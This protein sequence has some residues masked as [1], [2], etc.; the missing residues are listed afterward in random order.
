MTATPTPLSVLYVEPD[1]AYRERVERY[2]DGPESGMSVVAVPTLDAARSR[3]RDAGAEF[4]CVVAEYALPDADG[5]ELIE[6]VREENPALPVVV[7]T[8]R[9]AEGL[10]EEAFDRGATD[11]L[12]KQSGTEQYAVLRRRIEAAVATGRSADGGAASAETRGDADSTFAEV[13][14]VGYITFDAGGD[15]VHANPRA[16]SLLG[17]EASELR[18]LTYDAA[19]FDIVDSEGEPIPEEQLPFARALRSKSPVTDAE[20]GV[21]RPGGERVWL[22]VNATPLYEEG[23]G[24]EGDS[25]GDGDGADDGDGER[26]ET[27]RGVIATFQDVTNRV[28]V[29][30]TLNEVLDRTTDSFAA[31]DTEWRYTYVN[32]A[33]ARL[34]GRPAEDHIGQVIWDL[35]PDSRAFW[36]VSHEAMETQEPTSFEAY[37][38]EP[39]DRWT[40][41][42]LYPSESGLSI[43]LRDISNRKARERELE[44]YEAIVQTVTDGICVLDDEWRFTT[45]NDAFV[46]MTG[47]SREELVGSRADAVADVADPES[48]ARLHAELIEERR[49]VAAMESEVETKSGERLP[50]EAWLAPITFGDETHGVVGVVRDVT[51]RKRSAEAFTELYEAAHDL[52]SATTEEEIARIAVEASRELLSLPDAVLFRYDPD[53]RAFVHLAHSPEIASRYPPVPT[54]PADEASLIRRAF[55][56]DEVLAF[57]DV[58]DSETL[59]HTEIPMRRG[60]FIPLGEYG[61]LLAGETATGAFDDQTETLA[62]LLGTTIRAA[63]DRLADEQALRERQWE[64]RQQTARLERLNQINELIRGIDERL[65]DARTREAVERAVCEQLVANDRYA[66]A[67]VGEYDRETETVRPRTWEGMDR[68]YLEQLAA[69]DAEER[70]TEPADRAARERAVVV[71]PNVVDG[72]REN[73]WRREALSR[74]FQS[75]ISVPLHYDE[76]P[77]GVLTVYATRTDEFDA[78]TRTVYEE[79]GE[80]IAHAINGAETKQGLVADRVV[81]LELRLRATNETLHR[82]AAE[83]DCLLTYESVLP[84]SDDRYLVFFRTPATVAG[85]VERAAAELPSVRRLKALSTDE[86]SE[87]FEAVVTEPPPA[88]TFVEHG[89]VPRLIRTDG[90]TLT[91]TVEVP[92]ETNIRELIERLQGTYPDVELVA[93]R[94][95]EREVRTLDS[96]QTT[97]ASH[98]TERQLEVLVT[99]YYSGYFESPRYQTGEEIARS[100]GIT[101]PTFNYHLRRASRKLLSLLIAQQGGI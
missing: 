99:A 68:G 89:A 7:F 41:V 29:E 44:R 23:D 24:G 93:R 64:L 25:A 65:V 82:L 57:A 67:W 40:E 77:Y 3:L 50:V 35:Y 79:L 97:L 95:R 94:E 81:E 54:F 76:I 56:E 26:G 8:D 2:F 37:I 69:I 1:A 63:F 33:T 88:V 62:D 96:L 75:A 10:V 14:P 70:T 12:R 59:R 53:E 4:A 30:T 51:E 38:P 55:F 49:S 72:L 100:L 20:I 52:L 61:V 92:A 45:V 36:D 21:R 78:L 87:L 60:L 6:A 27:V 80:T 22:S 28:E 83:A 46:R 11:Y 101:Q 32:E 73:R 86:E 5:P 13:S 90:E 58:H 98:L 74:G 85:D 17:R 43:F 34:T 39:I 15:I 84:R 9:P 71:V 19:A 31:F 48:A 47:Y 42:Q 66:L 18:T 91:A 16:E